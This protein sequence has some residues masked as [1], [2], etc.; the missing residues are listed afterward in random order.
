LWDEKENDRH[1]VVILG[2]AG[3]ASVVTMAKLVMAWPLAAAIPQL[4]DVSR[5][6]KPCTVRVIDVAGSPS[7]RSQPFLPASRIATSK[8]SL[9]IVP[10][11]A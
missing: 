1:T 6:D 11:F 2:D 10:S 7:A 4:E 9:F 3:A 8:A 5:I